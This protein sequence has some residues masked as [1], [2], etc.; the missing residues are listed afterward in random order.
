[1]LG[2]SGVKERERRRAA[3]D[4]CVSTIER[5]R[6]I[7]M[8]LKDDGYKNTIAPETKREVEQMF[9]KKNRRNGES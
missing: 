9:T 5:L 1:M 8:R 7:N 2:L 3:V 6:R 4:T